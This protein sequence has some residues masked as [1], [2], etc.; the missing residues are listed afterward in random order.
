MPAAS[1]AKL[2]GPTIVGHGCANPEPSIMWQDTQKQ[3]KVGGHLE[4]YVGDIWSVCTLQNKLNLVSPSLPFNPLLR[5]CSVCLASHVTT[6]VSIS[7]LWTIQNRSPPH[8]PLSPAQGQ[9]LLQ[10]LSWGLYLRA[11]SS[12]PASPPGPGVLEEGPHLWPGELMYLGIWILRSYS[13]NPMGSSTTRC[14]LCVNFYLIC[15]M[16]AF[17]SLAGL[18]VHLGWILL[19]SGLGSMDPLCPGK[20]G[21][22]TSFQ[23]CNR[24]TSNWPQKNY[25]E[26]VTFLN[27]TSLLCLLQYVCAE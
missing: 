20:G 16:Y 19:S 13:N 5:W 3:P 10:P 8:P 6:G 22:A 4:L 23:L 25:F 14:F 9:A 7:L 15:T 11:P 24:N 26:T 12:G 18:G 2:F 17:S 1:L 27:T 21:M